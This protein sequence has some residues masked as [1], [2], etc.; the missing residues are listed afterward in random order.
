MRSWAASW[1]LLLVACSGGS[2]GLASLPPGNAEPSVMPEALDAATIS[3]LGSKKIQ[4]VIILVQENRT[5]DN[6]FHGFPGADTASTGRTHAGQVVPLAPGTLEEP[7]DLGHSHANFET[8]Y[9]GGKNDGFDEVPTSPALPTTTLASYQYVIQAEVQPYFDIASEFTIA[10]HNFASQNG[11]SFPGHEYLIA[12]QAAGADDD[13]SDV[14]PWGCD[15]PAGTTVPLYA[16][17]GSSKNVFPCFN[18]G[19]LGDLLDDAHRPW[20]YYTTFG[21]GQ[22]LEALPDPYDAVR[23][24][25]EGPD[26]RADTVTP[27][28]QILGDITGGRLAAVSW[29]NSPAA[30]SDHPQLNDGDGPSWIASV[31]NAVGKSP[32]YG[33]TAIFVT[34]DDFGGWYDHVVPHEYG[35]LGLGYRVPLL[36]VS[37]WSRHGYVSKRQHEFGSV[38]KFVEE[39]YH[40]PS[41]NARD[42]V[43]D[44]L[45]DCFDF[46]QTPRSFVPIKL[47]T[48][49]Y[50]LLALAKDTRPNDNY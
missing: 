4:H 5:F 19:T 36:V 28:T 15:A 37:Q 33:N 12:G 49:P 16:A 25:R 27:S 14:Q 29:V 11:P 42:A 38:L 44:D 32:Y 26:W 43:S 23:H 6:L 20:R 18:Y 3:K 13:P 9:D 8:D 50:K 31:V 48:P 40:L 2:G 7:Y 10:D 34:W 35:V 22:K 46:K 24:I 45:A 17:N 39:L 41:L 1:I 21:T 47:T 30:A